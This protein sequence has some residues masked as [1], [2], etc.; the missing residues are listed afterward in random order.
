[1]VI[2]AALSG[3]VA[4]IA[5]EVALNTASGRKTTERDIVEA[6]FIGAIPGVG[7][8]KGVGA[9]SYRAYQGRKVL[10]R[11]R[12]I[13]KPMFGRG[14]FG[15]LTGIGGSTIP[16]ITYRQAKRN[17]YIYAAMGG[18]PAARGM[19][20]AAGIS[21]A[22]D[23]IY[24]TENK[25]PPA[26]ETQRIQSSRKVGSKRAP[27]KLPKRIPRRNGRCPNGYRFSRKLNACVRK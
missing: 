21:K 11:Y 13:G 19:L 10:S 25:S 17:V 1:M 4:S 8:A 15:A 6:G 16:H 14:R 20:G 5:I 23:V 26:T 18:I 9:V 27:K 12:G 7:A 3:G 22:L 2:A 24:S